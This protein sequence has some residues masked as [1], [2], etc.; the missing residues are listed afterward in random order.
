MGFGGGAARKKER[1]ESVCG[2]C[3]C[4]RAR[5][6]VCVVL[7]PVAKG[8]SWTMNYVCVSDEG[9]ALGIEARSPSVQWKL[10]QR[11]CT[12]IFSDAGSYLITRK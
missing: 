8:C 9:A 5:A 1:E 10:E 4:A 7:S 11:D 2:V 6:H 3:V 12:R